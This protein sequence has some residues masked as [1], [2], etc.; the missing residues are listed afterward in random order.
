M[1]SYKSNPKS[2]SHPF[3]KIMDEKA[4]KDSK[5]ID[6]AYKNFMKD[7]NKDFIFDKKLP[8][9]KAK[10]DWKKIDDA[11]KKLMEDVN[12]YEKAKKD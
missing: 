7:V 10:K 8:D 6:D 4:K 1:D 11:Y 9:D 12:K 2:I 5:K 3:Y